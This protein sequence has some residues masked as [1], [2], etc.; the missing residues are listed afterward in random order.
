MRRRTTAAVLV[1]VNGQ[2]DLST[3]PT[4]EFGV[5]VRVAVLDDGEPVVGVGGVPDGQRGLEGQRRFAVLAV[6]SPAPGTCPH[7]GDRGA[8]RGGRE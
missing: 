7:C 5:R 1:T 6:K 3:S 4:G 8:P 2:T